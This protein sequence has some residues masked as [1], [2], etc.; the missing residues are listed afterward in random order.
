MV[1]RS[2][3]YVSEDQ[4]RL[5]LV[6]QGVTIGDVVRALNA[7][8]VSPRDLISVIVGLREAGALQADLKLI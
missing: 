2:D 5:L 6:P 7:I 4:N 8:G 3:I 1:P